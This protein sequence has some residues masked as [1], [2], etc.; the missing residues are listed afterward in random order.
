MEV[1]MM[2]ALQGVQAAMERLQSLKT[3]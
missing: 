1:E 2:R 3:E